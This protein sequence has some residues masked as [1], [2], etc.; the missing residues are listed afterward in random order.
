V[1]E[2]EWFQRSLRVSSKDDLKKF[3]ESWAGKERSWFTR[4]INDE[5]I[6]FAQ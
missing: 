4:G 6:F 3:M 2:N 5:P 1:K